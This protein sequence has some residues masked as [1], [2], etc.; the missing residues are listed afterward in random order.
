[1]CSLIMG[2][3]QM[4]VCS[5]QSFY[6]TMVWLIKKKLGVK[7]LN[8]LHRARATGDIKLFRFKVLRVAS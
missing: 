5:F 8:E 4:N 6:L 3:L 7:F 2:A 1:M